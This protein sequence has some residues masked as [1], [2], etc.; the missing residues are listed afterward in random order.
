MPWYIV[1]M[2][3]L[4]FIFT[5]L[6]LLVLFSAIAQADITEIARI[7]SVLDVN[8]AKGA[9]ST[10]ELAEAIY[11]EG[12]EAEVST[13]LIT[14][15]VLVESR[16]IA[17][18]YNEKSKDYGLMQIN[19]RTALAYKIN[20]KCL[21]QWRC[22]LR[23]GVHIL[24]D[25]RMHRPCAYNVGPSRSKTHVKLCLTYERKLANLK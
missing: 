22:N 2:K 25:M 15:V 14:R 10:Q 1:C 3:H 4:L 8:V 21:E 13:D 5:V 9:V 11:L 7:K 17:S 18:A 24:R 20:K 6:F 23:V 16:G 19:E 12:K